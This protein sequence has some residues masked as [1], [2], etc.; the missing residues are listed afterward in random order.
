MITRQT[1]VHFRNYKVSFRVFNDE[2]WLVTI[3]NISDELGAT[4]CECRNNWN[5]G[6]ASA[7][8]NYAEMVDDDEAQNLMYELVMS[9]DIDNGFTKYLPQPYSSSCYGCPFR[10][11][12]ESTPSVCIGG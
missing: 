12:C 4:G 2:T 7:F 10:E 8:V 3:D 11:D 9:E 1:V 6:L 5:K